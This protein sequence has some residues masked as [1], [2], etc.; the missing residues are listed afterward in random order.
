MPAL[1]LRANQQIAEIHTSA[2]PYPHISGFELWSF[3]LA[4]PWTNWAF[5]ISY[6]RL[7]CMTMN[8]SIIHHFISASAMHKNEPIDHPSFHFNSVRMILSRAVCIWMWLSPFW[9]SLATHSLKIIGSIRPFYCF[10]HVDG[11]IHRIEKRTMKTSRKNC[12]TIQ[13]YTPYCTMNSAV[14]ELG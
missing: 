7:S 11:K 3:F 5:V 2:L 4:S 14:I 10:L 9:N 8:Q 13:R 12:L 6:R 1:S